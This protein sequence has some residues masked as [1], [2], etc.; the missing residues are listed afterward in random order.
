VRL[1]YF[2]FIAQEPLSRYVGALTPELKKMIGQSTLATI[3]SVSAE[4]APCASP[5]SS[6]AVLDD[7]TLIW[8]DVRSPRTLNN[9]EGDPRTEILILDPISRKAVRIAGKV[10]I[11]SVNG[12]AAALLPHLQDRRAD[13]ERVRSLVTINVLKAELVQAPIYDTGFSEEEIKALWEE[14]YV[15]TARKT[16]L[17]MTP[18]PDF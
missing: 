3:A 16:V 7:D 17:D 12:R 1:C 15:P 4:G 5:L 14:H 18:P 9:L 6:I 8:A 10:S 13:L 11:F 2:A